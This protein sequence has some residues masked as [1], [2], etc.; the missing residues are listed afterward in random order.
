MHTNTKKLYMYSFR[1][2]QLASILSDNINCA[3]DGNRDMSSGHFSGNFVLYHLNIGY[4]ASLF[5]IFVV[6]EA[7]G[8]TST[9]SR[10]NS[11]LRHLVRKKPSQTTNF[12]MLAQ[13]LKSKRK[14]FEVNVF[15]YHTTP[16]AE[17]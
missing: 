4:V 10:S 2:H 14:C 1:Q 17:L 7:S 3:G 6:S 8:V 11:Q 15:F 12:S 16:Y 5:S 13:I 9:L